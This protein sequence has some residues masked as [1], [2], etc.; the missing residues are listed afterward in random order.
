[1]PKAKAKA[2]IT[3]EVDFEWDETG[4]WESSTVTVGPELDKKTLYGFFESDTNF[5]ELDM[6]LYKHME[7]MD[8]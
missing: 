7:K 3:I 6:K 1:M 5:F 2:K 8:D 4:T